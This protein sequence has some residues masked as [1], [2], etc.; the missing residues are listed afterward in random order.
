MSPPPSRSFSA[1]AIGAALPVAL[2][3]LMA[4]LNPQVAIAVPPKARAA[5][6]AAFPTGDDAVLDARE[7]LR[8]KDRAR[9]AALRNA[10]VADHHPLALWV[11]L[12][13]A[14]A[15]WSSP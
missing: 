5:A 10:L 12:R 4:L 13:Y 8:R 9:L 11:D 14:L 6:D 3:A 15:G 2:G 7:A 1:R